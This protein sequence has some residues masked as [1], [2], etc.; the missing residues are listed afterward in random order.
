MMGV[1][2]QIGIDPLVFWELTPRELTVLVDAYEIEEKLQHEKDMA[3][4]YL[5]AYWHRVKKMPS[6]KEVLGIKKPAK[7]TQTPEE[8]LE[9]VKRL[10]EAFG[11]TVSG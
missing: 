6:L 5:T 10:N 1:A 11:G 9:T 7:R 8:M 4:A 2:F 3:V